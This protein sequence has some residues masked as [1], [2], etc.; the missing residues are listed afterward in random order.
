MVR[1]ILI[2]ISILFFIILIIN[3]NKLSEYFKSDVILEATN[4]EDLGLKI[5][6][7]RKDNSFEYM[8]TS[9]LG[10]ESKKTGTYFINDNILK[11]NSENKLN[12]NT[13]SFYSNK[14]YYINEFGHKHN[15]KIKI[16]D[17]KYFKSIVVPLSKN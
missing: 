13:F 16:K 9:Y 7:L 17:E 1:Y 3:F 12:S 6:K 8:Y 2:I 10:F 5:L 14:L 11:L 15:F 4:N